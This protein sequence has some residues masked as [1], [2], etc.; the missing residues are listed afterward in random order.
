MITPSLWRG[1]SH[2]SKG[3]EK[4]ELIFAPPSRG[5]DRRK[6][7]SADRYNIWV[8]LVDKDEN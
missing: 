3:E 7:K 1:F 6:L 5:R 8:F 2:L 4:R